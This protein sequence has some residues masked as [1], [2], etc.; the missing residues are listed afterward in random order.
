MMQ[1]PEYEE[2]SCVLIPVTDDRYYIWNKNVKQ[3]WGGEDL[4]IEKK[5]SFNNL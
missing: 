5:A 1:I 2:L 3:F 4:N